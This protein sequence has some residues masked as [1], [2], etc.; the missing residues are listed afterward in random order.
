MMCSPGIQTGDE[1]VH[2]LRWYHKDDYGTGLT[3]LAKVPKIQRYIVKA[4]DNIDNE[5]VG[6][7]YTHM[8]YRNLNITRS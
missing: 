4:M 5:N 6:K 2:V 7:L 1:N 8:T 3:M